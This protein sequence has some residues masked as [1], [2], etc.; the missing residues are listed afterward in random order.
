MATTKAEG[1][2]A[3]EKRNKLYDPMALAI[4][5]GKMLSD[6][7]C[8][9]LDTDVDI[10]DPLYDSR[11]MHELTEEFILNVNAFGVHTAI[12]V[13]MRDGVPFVVAGRHRVRAARRVNRDRTKTG[14]P[15]MTIEASVEPGKDD[16]RL[17]GIMDSENAARFNDGFTEVITK[18][19][20]RMGRGVSLEDAAIQF[21]MPLERAKS[22]LGFDDAA[23]DV[24]RD[25]VHRDI[26]S[27]TAGMEIV[28]AGGPDAQRAALRAML[29]DAGLIDAP[30]GVGELTQEQFEH[31]SKTDEV[32]TAALKK[33]SA[34][35]PASKKRANKKLSVS[36]ARTA[37][38]ATTKPT[39]QLG[40]PDMKTKTKLLQ[41]LRDKSHAKAS[42]KTLSFWEGAE[43][44]LTLIMGG[45]EAKETDARLTDMLKDVRKAMKAGAR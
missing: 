26:M 28:R 29:E 36:A 37:T 22:W 2:T 17:M 23:I 44:M 20:G 42:E 1:K 34:A 18:I 4:A 5:G 15:L 6:D 31:A 32:L 38:K 12:K 41:A 25:F 27:V 43:N 8:G 39:A 3:T 35:P 9:P 33:A 14:Q 24:L 16:R 21:N 11:L 7:E 30:L 45:D 19:R 40:V 10:D 13:T